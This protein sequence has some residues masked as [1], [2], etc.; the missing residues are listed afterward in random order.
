MEIAEFLS[1]IEKD[2]Q[3][4]R[5]VVR[6]YQKIKE[7]GDLI[8][9]EKFLLKKEKEIGGLKSEY[10]K[11]L[12]ENFYK[13]IADFLQAE[14]DTLREKFGREL[15]E[16]VERE[17]KVIKGQYPDLKIGL[18]TLEVNF[19]GNYA[20]LY[21]GN[22]LEMIRR[23]IPLNPPLILRAIQEFY[24]SLKPKEF[25]PQ[26]FLQKLFLAYRHFLSTNKKGEGERVF[27]VDLLP[28][29]AFAI[30][31]KEFR[32]DPRRR[33]FREYPRYRFSYDLYQLIN[34]GM[35]EVAGY[36]FSLAVATFDQTL[37]KRKALWVPIN[38]EG[39]GVYYSTI[40]FLPER[41]T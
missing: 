6:L 20:H 25:H 2:A 35:R 5:R 38:E 9:I 16:L 22:K 3:R 30:Q 13:E 39:E 14:K 29:I 15:K 1:E 10:L 26:L 24:Q 17:G 41:E 11:N 28:E 19:L 12:A 21:W 7:K 37:E 8:K 40:A 34:S 18:L 32:E 36:T 33:N 31:G 4:L 23:K 27:L